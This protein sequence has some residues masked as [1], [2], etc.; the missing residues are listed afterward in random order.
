MIYFYKMTQNIF[1]FENLIE[2]KDEAQIKFREEVEE[3]NVEYKLRLDAKNE[4]SLKKMK[5]QM[6][7]RFEEGKELTGKRECHYVLGIYDNGKLGNLTENQID[8][9]FEI[10]KNVVETCDAIITYSEKK[11]YNN[12]WIIFASLLQILDKKITE[13]NVGFVGYSQTGKTTTISN[14]VFGQLDDGNGSARQN[15][16]RHEHEK[17]SGYT[18]SIKKEIIGIK[19]NAIINYNTGINISWER[20]ANMSDR[21]L[22]LI[23]LP[24]S[25]QYIKTILFGLSAYNF[26]A[27]VI[28]NEN[29]ENSE[30]SENR[31]NNLNNLYIEYAKNLNIPYIIVEISD[32]ISPYIVTPANFNSFFPEQKSYYDEKFYPAKKENKSTKEEDNLLEEKQKI[33]KITNTKI[34]GIKPLISFLTRIKKQENNILENKENSQNIFSITDMVS[35]PDTGIVYSGEMM[36]GKLSINDDIFLTNGNLTFN[37]KIQSIH[38]KQ[39]FSD[40]LYTNEMGAILLSGTNMDIQ[41]LSKHMIITTHQL[42]SHT[43]ILFETKTTYNIIKNI[44]LTIYINN[45]II[46]GIVKDIILD[47]NNNTKYLLSLK[48]NIIIIPKKRNYGFAKIDNKIFIIEI[49]L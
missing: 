19:N 2:I 49:I 29:S 15:I 33:F 46:K 48:K 21:I 30:N 42:Q 37:L 8:V 20:I 40:T 25:P 24:G 14:I 45:N 34:N 27:L 44:E 35:I 16:F 10:F 41:K 39:T 6:N 3:G 7:W 18:S 22:C 9:T 28:F 43:Q 5:N 38:K 12:S 47:S 13:I 31:D 23:D 11:C 4:S 36:S 26:D 17:T 32:I 1:N